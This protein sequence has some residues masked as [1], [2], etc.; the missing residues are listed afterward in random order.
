MRRGKR[1]ARVRPWKRRAGLPSA[2][3]PCNDAVK[4]SER[5]VGG[6][7]LGLELQNMCPDDFTDGALILRRKS[8]LGRAEEQAGAV[9]DRT[10][11]DIIA[12]VKRRTDF[13]PSSRRVVGDAVRQRARVEK[14]PSVVGSWCF[15][16][17]C[18]LAGDD[19]GPHPLRQP[20]ADILH[21]GRHVGR[22]LTQAFEMR[23]D[24]LKP[25]R[26]DFDFE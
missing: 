5:L 17:A 16:A 12:V 9:M 23:L 11:V 4:N 24:T 20:P 1:A 26:F 2:E 7:G 19:A 25:V 13:D 21:N 6:I 8:S 22:A 15:P 18:R 10:P 14:R 3:H